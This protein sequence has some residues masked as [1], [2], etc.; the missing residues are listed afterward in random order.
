MSHSLAPANWAS[1]GSP[2]GS[3]ASTSATL[4][5]HRLSPASS[6]VNPAQRATGLAPI[7]PYYS[8]IGGGAAPSFGPSF[9][10]TSMLEK[11][12]LL[13][14]C[15]RHIKRTTRRRRPSGHRTSRELSHDPYTGWSFM[16]T[17]AKQQHPAA[18]YHYEG[19]N[20]LGKLY[21]RSGFH[22]QIHHNGKV[23]GTRQENSR[24]G[25]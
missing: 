1:F 14:S 22:L 8:S 23:N 9:D 21:C 25:K 6:V 24:F 13:K 3:L 10:L 2:G 11:G 7:P 12:A 5:S 20:R 16:N 15:M 19:T 4:A 17:G 18:F